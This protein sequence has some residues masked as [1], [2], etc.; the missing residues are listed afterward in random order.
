MSGVGDNHNDINDDSRLSADEEQDDVVT[1]ERSTDIEQDDT[2]AT[3]PGCCGHGGADGSARGS[4]E[5]FV[6]GL[7]LE[8]GKTE[9]RMEEDGN[10]GKEESEQTEDKL[11]Y[12]G[13]TCS[14]QSFK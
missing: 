6:A 14:K 10:P 4:T 5:D 7:S 8:A 1:I 12:Q 3:Q 11:E 2:E 9:E 13:K